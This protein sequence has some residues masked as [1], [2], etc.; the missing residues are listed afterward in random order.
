MPK[1]DLKSGSVHW[2]TDIGQ[3]C[4][5]KLRRLLIN[6]NDAP[7]LFVS[8]TFLSYEKGW[9]LPFVEIKLDDQVNEK[10]IF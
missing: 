10:F 7:F 6:P 1:R 4:I 3:Q 9:P 5:R 8:V 2:K